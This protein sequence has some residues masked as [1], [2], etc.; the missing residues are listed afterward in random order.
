MEKN[1]R[2][3]NCPFT[4]INPALFAPCSLRLGYMSNLLRLIVSQT[5][6]E[7]YNF[8]IYWDQGPIFLNQFSRC[9]C[10]LNTPLWRLSIV[11]IS[12]SVS[13]SK[14]CRWRSGKPLKTRKWVKIRCFEARL[15][16]FVLCLDFSLQSWLVQVVLYFPT[17]FSANHVVDIVFLTVLKSS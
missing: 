3:V 2:A 15:V 16:Q 4:P 11:W 14:N 1:N 8:I 6:H 13:D 10:H 5:R 17:A 7:A 12:I 9:R